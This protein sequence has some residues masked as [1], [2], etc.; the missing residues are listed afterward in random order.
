MLEINSF[1]S[2]KKILKKVNEHST[3]QWFSIPKKERINLNKDS[4]IKQTN[5]NVLFKTCLVVEKI[6]KDIKYYSTDDTGD[7]TETESENSPVSLEDYSATFQIELPEMDDNV[8]DNTEGADARR[9]VKI[10]TRFLERECGLESLE[11]SKVE[12]EDVDEDEYTPKIKLAG[13]DEEPDIEF[14]SVTI[15]IDELQKA[16]EIV[17]KFLNDHKVKQ[18]EIDKNLPYYI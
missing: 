1:N 13:L 12:G 4:W 17:K 3:K 2:Y 8:M 5:E 15:S 10:S 6:F 9:A 16:R 11:M 7:D 14:F 18:S